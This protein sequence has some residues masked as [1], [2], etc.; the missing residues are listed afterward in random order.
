MKKT[1]SIENFVDSLMR[2]QLSVQQQISL[3]IHQ[4]N[5]TGGSTNKKE[6]T[7][8]GAACNDVTNCVLCINKDGC[9]GSTNLQYCSNQVHIEALCKD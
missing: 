1:K 4:D 8:S 2:K 9:L 3:V 6:C 7:N 5:L